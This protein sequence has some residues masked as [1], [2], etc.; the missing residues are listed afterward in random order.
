MARGN[1]WRFIVLRAIRKKNR[2]GVLKD[3]TM[4]VKA[5]E[6]GDFQV[7]VELE[8]PE[9]IRGNAEAATRVEE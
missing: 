8:T 7:D 2:G 5:E 1:Q 6:Q 9:E 4:G 3:E